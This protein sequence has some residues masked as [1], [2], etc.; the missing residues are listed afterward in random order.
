MKFCGH[1]NDKKIPVA[2]DMLVWFRNQYW[3]GKDWLTQLDSKMAYLGA[4]VAID[5]LFRISEYVLVQGSDH[6]MRCKDI[7]IEK[8]TDT[9][10]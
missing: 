7:A 6:M 3:V 1:R 4:A 5:G 9:Y 8:N 10:T 2:C